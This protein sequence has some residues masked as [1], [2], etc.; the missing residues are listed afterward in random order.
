MDDY[1]LG[2]AILFKG[3]VLP[4]RVLPSGSFANNSEISLA[5]ILY[6]FN[7]ELESRFFEK[8]SKVS[9]LHEGRKD[10]EDRDVDHDLRRGKFWR[11]HVSFFNRSIKR[12]KEE[13]GKGERITLVKPI[14]NFRS[15]IDTISFGQIQALKR[16]VGEKWNNWFNY[17]IAISRSVRLFINSR[18]NFSP[19]GREIILSDGNG[20]E[21]PYLLILKRTR[22]ITGIIIRTSFIFI[23][24]PLKNERAP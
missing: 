11:G 2:K 16:Y 5:S 8:E 24:G 9:C 13:K 18:G 19:G 21:L 3:G 1:C 20:S 17:F 10:L 6:N 7:K 14:S 23:H 12:E 22:L 4:P 15:V